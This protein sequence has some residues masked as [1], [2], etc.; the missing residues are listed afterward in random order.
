MA[1]QKETP[2][3]ELDRLP[4]FEPHEDFSPNSIDPK[5]GKNRLFSQERESKIKEILA[6]YVSEA[7][8]DDFLRR[9]LRALVIYE[10]QAERRAS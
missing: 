5:T 9:A 10:Q 3:E 4:Q 1:K 7:S 6:P 2:R 8:L